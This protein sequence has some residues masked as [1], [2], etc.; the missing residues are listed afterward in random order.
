[1]P[2]P[3]F[4]GRSN[5]RLGADDAIVLC[6][7]LTFELERDVRDAEA[8]AHHAV[9]RAHDRSSLAHAPV[10][11]QDVRRERYCASVPQIVPALE[12]QGEQRGQWKPEVIA[13]AETNT[14]LTFGAMLAVL[15]LKALKG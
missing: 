2:V 1:M 5:H 4:L 13:K 11:D 7:V 15:A 3:Q 10:F 14:F 6:A 8:L 12:P 9:N